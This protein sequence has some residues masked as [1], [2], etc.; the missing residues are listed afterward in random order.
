MFRVCVLSVNLVML[1]STPCSGG[2]SAGDPEIIEVLYIS[3]CL[4]HGSLFGAVVDKILGGDP[5]VSVLGVPIPG[6]HAIDNL[7]K[8]PGLI[9]RAMRMYMPRNYEQ[10]LNERDTVILVE[11]PCGNTQYPEAC[12]DPKWISWLVRGVQ[13]E[14]LSLSMWGGDASFGGGA[15]GYKS[16]SDTMLDAILPLVSLG[17][18]NPSGQAA[19]HRPCFSDP[20]HP[21]A[22][23]PWESSPPVE[24]LNKVVLKSGATLLAEAAARNLRYPWIAWWRSGEGKVVG[25]AQ[26]FGSMGTTNR[27]REEWKW[28]QDFII[29]LTYSATDKPIPE[30]INRAHRIR[31]EINTHISK[32]SMLIS[33]LDFVEKFGARTVG[34]YAELEAINDLEKVAEQYYRR[35][36]YE[37]ASEIFE[38]VHG[39]WNDLNTKT[40]KVKEKALFWV[41]LIE[42]LAVSGVALFSGVFLWMIMIKR[43][44]Y[45]EIGTTRMLEA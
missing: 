32:T 3:R 27:F 29:Y 43:R 33:L 9:S 15:L 35:D 28:Y 10:L 11:A 16:W 17:D 44:L 38:E 4:A 26:V 14:G 8:D 1:V 12:F 23:L 40:I 19:I 36:D 41:Y 25:D 45:R 20:K 13:A 31:E 7:R 21:L 22:A 30:D 2:L 37:T 34:L 5:S 24:L 18:Y 42:W 6:H 39:A